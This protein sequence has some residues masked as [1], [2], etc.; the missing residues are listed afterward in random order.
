MR[1]GLALLLGLPLLGLSPDAA[2]QRPIQPRF[3]AGF[4]AL[5]AP[6]G[7]DLVEEGL[8]LG[9]RGRV[10]LPVNRDLSFALSMGIVGF[11]FGG[12]DDASYLAHP[13]LSVIL[14]LPGSRSARYLMGGFGGFI[15][16][17]NP[18]NFG[19]PDGG[20]AI[21][22]GAGWAFPLSETSLYV[23]IDPSLIIGA[24]ETTVVLPARV[25]I[26]F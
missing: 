19:V 2:A 18:D 24:S 11:V 21:H 23:E 10:A 17:E 20:P 4:E 14:T 8:G 15:P 9:V 1:V 22:L 12:Q 13:Q 25:G 26:I 6:P 7:Q 5:V 3:G 16:L